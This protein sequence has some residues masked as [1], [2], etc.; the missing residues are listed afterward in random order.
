MK[1]K[2]IFSSFLIIFLFV[3]PLSAQES[4]KKEVPD[5][6]VSL[7]SYGIV[8]DKS[9]NKLYLYS[10]SQGSLKL[11]KSFSCSTGEKNGNKFRAGD[12]RTPEGVYFFTR[13][14]T[15]GILPKHGIMAFPLNYPNLIDKRLRKGGDGIWLHGVD[16]KF[17]KAK[18]L[19]DTKG[20]VAVRN[21]DLLEL[22]EIIKIKE[23]PFIIVD[24]ISYASP[25]IIEKEREEINSFI[26][27]WKTSWESKNIAHYLS[28]YS[29]DFYSRGMDRKKWERYKEKVISNKKF[30][31]IKIEN[32]KI[33]RYR[34]ANRFG[35][36]AVCSFNQYY[37]S[38]RFKDRCKKVL[39]LKKQPDNWKILGEEVL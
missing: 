27:S 15:Q 13:R 26:S 22:A 29:Q 37:S 11:I 21:K 18:K 28:L 23:T 17:E 9:A 24:K 31:K 34:K 39:Y 8:C 16:K 36:I 7:S 25:E 35:D 33:L 38:D 20:C 10:S 2:L 19:P 5:V 1:T 6:L 3:L 12:K 30:I 32:L 14:L 4:L